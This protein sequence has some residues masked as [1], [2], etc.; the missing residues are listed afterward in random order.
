MGSVAIGPQLD[1]TEL[2]DELEQLQQA[3]LENK[4]L[5]TGSL[6]VDRLPAVANGES[7]LILP[8]PYMHGDSYQPTAFQ[9][10]GKRLPSRRTTRKR[11]SESC[12]PRWPCERGPWQKIA[13]SRHGCGHEPDSSFH[14]RLI[15]AG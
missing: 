11:S 7:E 1:E 15:V 5:E 13:L 14:Q 12:R 8:T 10:K 6:P 4:M 9:S 2:E 3:E